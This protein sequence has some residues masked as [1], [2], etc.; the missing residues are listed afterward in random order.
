MTL[1]VDDIY[2]ISHS[3]VREHSRALNVVGVTSTDGGSDRVELLIT[4]EG[5]H[6]QPCRFV[7][8]VSRA[9]ADE[10]ERQLR[11]KLHAALN[12]HWRDRS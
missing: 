2:G 12:A 7:I 6:T 1:S 5:C 8:N 11:A 10:F 4:I 9:H 3:V